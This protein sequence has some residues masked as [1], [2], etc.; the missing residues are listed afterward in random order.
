[1]TKLVWTALHA[2]VDLYRGIHAYQD[3][4]RA[5]ARVE[6]SRAL[7]R[8]ADCWRI[9]DAQITP[10]RFLLGEEMTV[11]DLYVAVA[12][13]WTPRRRRFYAEAPGMAGCSALR[14]PGGTLSAA[15]VTAGASPDS[16]NATMMILVMFST[17]RGPSDMCP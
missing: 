10:G 12:S 3:G 15:M 16:P 4:D 8:I 17:M 1:M 6:T 14:L 9:M 13:R 5:R 11:L 7:S 2:S